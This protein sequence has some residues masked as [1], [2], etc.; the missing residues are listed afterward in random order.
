MSLVLR[1][2]HTPRTFWHDVV[3]R[4]ITDGNANTCQ[5]LVD[6][7]RVA[8]TLHSPTAGNDLVACCLTQV[9]APLADD[10]LQ[11]RVHSW[12]LED[13][14]GRN[15]GLTQTALQQQ[16]ILQNQRL[17][18]LVNNQQARANAPV[19]VSSK[20]PNYATVL[21]RLCQVT[22]DEDLPPLWRQLATAARTERSAVIQFC[23]EERA[24][25]VR[26]PSPVATP[27]LVE[28]L[29]NFRF[30]SPDVD[31][32]TA[33]ASLFIIV[34]VHEAG[35]PRTARGRQ[36][37]YDMVHSGNVAPTLDQ[38][39]Q[40]VDTAPRMATNL[41]QLLHSLRG[42]SVLLDCM[43]GSDHPLAKGFH[44]FVM[45]WDRRGQA[46]VDSHF[47]TAQLTPFVPM[48]MRRV[49][50]LAQVW[51]NTATT[52]STTEPPPDFMEMI[53]DVQHRQWAKYPSILGRYVETQAPLT[54]GGI[55]LAIDETVPPPRS[56]PD[57]NRQPRGGNQQRQAVTNPSP[58]S[59]FVTRYARHQGRMRDLTRDAG[60]RLPLA[61]NGTS[62]LCLSYCLTGQCFSNCCHA[63]THRPLTVTEE[64]RVT[65]FL[66]TA[67]LE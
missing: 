50:L 33:G 23:L 64:G 45:E 9:Q 66:V 14:P 19:T 63:G 59:G 17:Q 34:S 62:Q 46:E 10:T 2:Q 57:G 55:P 28:M 61:D 56:P 11:N 39:H 47:T 48:V 60:A 37:V 27:E 21:R 13:L 16:V 1:R 54:G 32:L 12:V 4:I 29:V 67:G 49:Q 52:A 36:L 51:F 58:N 7:A 42:Y 40:L 6:W 18:D 26:F 38:L 20:F 5:V 15:V 35:S 43:L 41:I 44:G 65:A 25:A 31:D 22:R 8:L 53:R 3:H 30:T 24:R